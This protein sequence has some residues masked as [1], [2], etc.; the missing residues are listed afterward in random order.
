MAESKQ[1]QIYFAGSISGGR[2]DQPEYETI[3]A[4]LKGHGEVLSAHVADATLTQKGMLFG[5]LSDDQ[6]R[7]FL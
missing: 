7:G 6:K 2:D 3:V 1:R 4:L 5:R